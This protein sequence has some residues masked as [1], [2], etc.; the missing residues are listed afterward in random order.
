MPLNTS[1]PTWPGS[2]GY[3]SHNHLSLAAGDIANATLIGMDAH[4]GT[5]VD[6]PRHFVLEGATIDEVGLSALVGPAIVADV[7][8]SGDA[9]DAA[10]LDGCD[11]PDGSE[12]LLLRTGNSARA[13]IEH[14]PF[15]PDYAA[16][17]PD[18]AQWV[19]DRGIRLIGIDY[20]SIQRYADP[21]DVHET[22]LQAG[23]LILE[24]LDLRAVAPGPW[25]LVCLPLRVTGVE[26]APARAVLMEAGWHG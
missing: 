10:T 13:G 11:I 17:T 24:G 26:A 8:G 9:I 2:P 16:L 15:Q 7:S 1:T 20:L 14:G 4:C 21:P 22:L 12:R 19:V 5:H 23:V 6:A 25:T 18:A 3:A